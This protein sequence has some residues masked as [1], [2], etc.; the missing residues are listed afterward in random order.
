MMVDAKEM[1]LGMLDSRGDSGYNGVGFVQIS[2]ISMIQENNPLEQNHSEGNTPFVAI[3][4]IL[5]NWQTFLAFNMVPLINC[6][7]WSFVL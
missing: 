4:E 1:E 6:T 3:S 2:K 7:F 5:M